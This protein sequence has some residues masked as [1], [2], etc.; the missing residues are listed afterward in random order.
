LNAVFDSDGEGVHLRRTLVSLSDSAIGFDGGAGMKVTG[1]LVLVSSHPAK[2][3]PTIASES[4]SK[5]R[6]IGILQRVVKQRTQSAAKIL[7][8]ERVARKNGR[9]TD[10]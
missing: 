5:R 3:A 1:V 9:L 8:H 6:F 2:N 10:L 4:A 7:P